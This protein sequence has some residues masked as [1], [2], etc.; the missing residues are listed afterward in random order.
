MAGGSLPM[1]LFPLISSHSRETP[2]SQ[3]PSKLLKV[4]DEMGFLGRE[5]LTACELPTLGWPISGH[6]GFLC[7]SWWL[8][9]E[10]LPQIRLETFSALDA[11]R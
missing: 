6:C 2:K 8:A 9:R 4:G 11:V 3:T 10:A 1:H 5:E 7:T